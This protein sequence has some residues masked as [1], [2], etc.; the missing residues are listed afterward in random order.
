MKFGVAKD[1]ITPTVSMCLACPQCDRDKGFK[2][3]HDDVYV[4]CLVLDDG[5][6]KTV[7]MSFDLL[8]HD[9][10]LNKAVE[11][12]AEEKY[13]I[14]PSAVVIACTHSHMAPAALG[15][16]PGFHNDRYE[17]FL[18]TRACDCLDRAMCAMREGILEYGV[19]DAPFNVSRRGMRDGKPAN[20][21]NADY[22]HDT[23]F[24]L[25]CV[26]D[27][28]GNLCS[29]VMNFPCHPVFYP[30]STGVSGE[31]PARVCQYIDIENYGCISMYF[32]SACGDVRPNVTADF[33]NNC[34]KAPMTFADIDAFSRDMAKSV[35]VFV[36]NGGCK[37]K[38]LSVDSDAFEIELPM[39]KAP[40]EYFENYLRD[41]GDDMTNPNC[42]NAD[43]IVNGGYD[44]M[45]ESLPLYCQTVRISD[46]LYIAAMGGEPCFG[47]KQAVKAA[48]GE[49]S[50]LFIGYTDSCA[51]IVDDKTLGE[52]GYE[53][54]CHLEYGLPGPFKPGVD[55]KYTAAF[56]E[57]Y[58]KIK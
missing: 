28:S 10:S 56:A 9:R 27:L 17:A 23:E 22:P 49:K 13:G 40:L 48:F 3:I 47:V 34:W 35:C 50:V 31:F 20:A 18:V 45:P 42:V 41:Y 24:A 21:P 2:E 19:F 38:T 25:L 54:T 57:S 4:R 43:I 52:G 14:S 5:N 16:N 37:E 46:D 29:L 44:T 33:E 39:E 11:K 12:Y 32:Q 1:I 53:P 15:Y 55:E 36:K 30:T 58:R 26:R 7:L 51:Y 6:K 8:F